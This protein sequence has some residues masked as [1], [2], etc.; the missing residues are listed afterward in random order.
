MMTVMGLSIEVFVDFALQYHVV[1][2]QHL[3]EG[4]VF[5]TNE[6]VVE[7]DGKTTSSNELAQCGAKGLEV[8]SWVS[9]WRD[10]LSVI[11]IDL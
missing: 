8:F 7:G 4:F 2:A 3:V 11:G 5:W 6:R 9:A 1:V 10:V